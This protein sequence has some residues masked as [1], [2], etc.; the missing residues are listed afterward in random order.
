LKRTDFV[1]RDR[2]YLVIFT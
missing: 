1:F 2:T